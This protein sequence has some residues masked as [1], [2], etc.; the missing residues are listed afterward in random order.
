MQQVSR[1]QIS[2]VETGPVSQT[3]TL[4]KSRGKMDTDFPNI[5][6]PVGGSAHTWFP[7]RLR[8]QLSSYFLEGQ[9]SHH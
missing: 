2:G 9:K 7:V 6:Q 4:G 1:T 8:A 5:T 3:S